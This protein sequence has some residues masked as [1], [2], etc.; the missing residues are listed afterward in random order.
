LKFC[1]FLLSLS[2]SLSLSL[3][4]CLHGVLLSPDIDSPGSVMKHYI[5][6]PSWLSLV[7][8]QR[9]TQFFFFFFFTSARM[10]HGTTTLTRF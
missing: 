8:A 2:L 10:P 9:K 6:P 3:W 7:G 4:V 1:A 5:P